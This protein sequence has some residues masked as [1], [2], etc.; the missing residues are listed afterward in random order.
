MRDDEP[1]TL[2]VYL[3]GP[4]EEIGLENDPLTFLGRAPNRKGAAKLIREAT[5]DGDYTARDVYFSAR[6]NAYFAEEG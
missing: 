5:G 6:R 3:C 2:P 4:G 1:E